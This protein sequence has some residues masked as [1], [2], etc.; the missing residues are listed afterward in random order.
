MSPSVSGPE[1]VTRAVGAAVPGPDQR[2]ER[3]LVNAPATGGCVAAAPCVASER[4]AARCTH[5]RRSCGVPSY[6]ALPARRWSRRRASRRRRP[7]A[8]RRRP[9]PSRSCAITAPP[10]AS[11]RRVRTGVDVDLDARASPSCTH[12]ARMSWRARRVRG[13]PWHQGRGGVRARASRRE[14]LQRLR[15]RSGSRASQAYGARRATS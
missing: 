15:I 13:R 14:R 5:R 11:S 10:R 3:V 8:R 12:E 9:R 6:V 2:L 7:A 1:R 4:R